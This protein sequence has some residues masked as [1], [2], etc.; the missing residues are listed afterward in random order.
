MWARPQLSRTIV[1]RSAWRSQRTG[2]GAWTRSAARGAQDSTR[3]S[4]SFFTMADLLGRR[5]PHGSLAPG[6]MP[7]TG[8]VGP[9][10]ARCTRRRE[11]RASDER[12]RERAT[13]LTR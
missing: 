11:D 12:A 5:W 2:S 6:E 8:A 7:A 9:L 4:G 1:T 3:S 13:L 10:L